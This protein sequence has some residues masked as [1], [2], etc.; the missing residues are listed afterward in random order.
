MTLAAQQSAQ[1]RTPLYNLHVAKGARMGPFAGY[2]MPIQYPSGV[3]KEHVHTRRVFR[4]ASFVHEREGRS[5]K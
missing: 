5:A 2:E 1:K 4:V 3:M